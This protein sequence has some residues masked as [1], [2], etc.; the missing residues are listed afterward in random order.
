[1][2][3]KKILSRIMLAL[4]A[5]SII[6]LIIVLFSG[7]TSNTKSISENLTKYNLNLENKTLK[8]I[9]DMGLIVDLDIMFLKEFYDGTYSK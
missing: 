2:K 9:S 6:A 3:L 5:V 4:C 8:I 1:M 7:C